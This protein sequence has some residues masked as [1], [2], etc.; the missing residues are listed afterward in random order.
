MSEQFFRFVKRDQVSAYKVLGWQTV[1]VRRVVHHDDYSVMMEW[2]GVGEPV[3][4]KK[5]RR[6]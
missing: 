1:S 5:E 4:P 6:Q 3:E 2:I